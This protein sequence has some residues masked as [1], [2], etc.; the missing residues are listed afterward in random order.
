M[1]SLS[2]KTLSCSLNSS[3][4]G[5]SHKRIP[6]SQFQVLQNIVLLYMYKNIFFGSG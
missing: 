2:E 1:S 3:D 4:N 6:L 5:K